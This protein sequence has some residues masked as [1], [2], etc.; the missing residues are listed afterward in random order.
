MQLICP[1][2]GSEDYECYDIVGEGTPNPE[3]LCLC[4]ECET[5][6]RIHYVAT[7]ITKD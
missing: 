5:D 3:A 7:H 4:Y 2:C 6:F 1:V